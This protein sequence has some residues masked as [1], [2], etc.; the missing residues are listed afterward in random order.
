MHSKNHIYTPILR[1]FLLV[2]CTCIGLAAALDTNTLNEAALGKSPVQSPISIKACSKSY[3][4]NKEVYLP[5]FGN[6]SDC[7]AAD[8]ITYRKMSLKYCA[9]DQKYRLQQPLVGVYLNKDLIYFPDSLDQYDGDLLAGINA[10]WAA[11][12]TLEYLQKGFPV[13][14]KS[15]DDQNQMVNINLRHPLVNG[16]E[17]YFLPTR[18][19]VMINQLR[20]K[21][22]GPNFSAPHWT[23]LEAITHEIGHGVI[24]NYYGI[25]EIDTLEN[26]ET[27]YMMEGLADIFTIL[28]TKYYAQQ[29]IICPDDFDWVMQFHTRQANYNRYLNDPEKSVIPSAIGNITQAATYKGATWQELIDNPA[30][31]QSSKRY[32]ASGP[33]A[34]WFYI[35]SEGK[36]GENDLGNAYAVDGIGSDL[37]EKVLFDGLALIKAAKNSSPNFQELKTATLTAAKMA[38]DTLSFSYPLVG[39]VQNA[40]YAVGLSTHEYVNLCPLEASTISQLYNP[41]E[42]NWRLFL[43]DIERISNDPEELQIQVFDAKGHLI[44]KTNEPTDFAWT[45]TTAPDE[46]IYWIKITQTGKDIWCGKIAYMYF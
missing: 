42:Q 26:I 6:R 18:S 1:L 40:W 31:S 23:Q 28:A 12:I 13:P 21:A 20:L 45:K 44:S 11:T 15:F 2:F 5:T 22:H 39:S 4:V 38:D 14:L 30:I 46:G 43:P 9:A 29:K 10:F 24:N 36:R 34:H 32:V 37:A 17:W 27:L 35:L 41:I 8:S 3:L 16:M 25:S 33:I 19:S 7:N